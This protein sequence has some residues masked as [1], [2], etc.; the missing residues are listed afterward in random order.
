MRRPVIGQYSIIRKR[1]QLNMHQAMN[2]SPLTI[3]I[4]A[5]WIRSLH[6]INDFVIGLLLQWF[7][8]DLWYTYFSR[9]SSTHLFIEMFH[10]YQVPL[11]IACAAMDQNVPHKRVFSINTKNH[12]TLQLYQA[13]RKL[14]FLHRILLENLTLIFFFETEPHTKLVAIHHNIMSRWID[15]KIYLSNPFFWKNPDQF[16]KHS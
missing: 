3:C 16:F 10:A 6:F 11:N 2:F 1:G 8:L 9:G 4:S 13:K 7:Y 12:S 5:P 14:I 15:K